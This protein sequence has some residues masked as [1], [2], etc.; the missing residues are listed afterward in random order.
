MV[1]LLPRRQFA[2][3]VD[4]DPRGAHAAAA[5]AERGAGTVTV[6]TQLH[7]PARTTAA[8]SSV[9]VGAESNS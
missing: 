2:V 8:L 9:L 7:T 3:G 6:A 5:V 4:D 1:D